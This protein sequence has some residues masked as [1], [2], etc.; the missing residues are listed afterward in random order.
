MMNYKR[1]AIL[2]IQITE[3]IR[4]NSLYV[5]NIFVD[6]IQRNACTKI[7]SNILQ[8]IK[9]SAKTCNYFDITIICVQREK[10]EYHINARREM[11]VFDITASE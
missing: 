5:P 9:R 10:A 4:N 1:S 7:K 2:K 8:I 3:D 6:F 11:F